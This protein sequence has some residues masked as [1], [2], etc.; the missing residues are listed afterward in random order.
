VPALASVQEVDMK[1]IL[2]IL[3]LATGLGFGGAA[4]A[5]FQDGLDAYESENYATALQEWRSLALR[6]DAIAQQKLGH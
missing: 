5:D 2:A 4:R 6:G 1:A 3:T